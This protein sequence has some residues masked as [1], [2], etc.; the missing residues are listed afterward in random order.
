MALLAGLFASI[1]GARGLGDVAVTTLFLNRV[2]AASL[3]WLFIALGMVSL[4]VALAYGAGIGRL[5]RRAFFVGLLVGF[6]AVLGV[7]RLATLA[8][9]VPVY[10][11]LWVVVNVINAILLT[12]VWTIAGTTLD[13]RQAKRLFPLCTSAAIAGSFAGTLASGPLAGL[14][15]TENLVLL[16][17]VVL[18]L[19]SAIAS[20]IAV[21]QG[22]AARATTVRTSLLVQLRRGFDDV[23]AS[24][25]MRLIAVAYVLFAVLMFSVSFPY[26]GA[27]ATGFAGNEAGLATTVGLI[28]TAVTAISFVVSLAIANRVYVRFGV[29]AAALILPVVYVLGFGVWLVQF[30]LATAVAFVVVQQVVQRSL[31]NAAWSALYNVVPSD[32]RPQVL[33]FIDGVPGQL[34]T[35]LS[36]VLLLLA[37]ALFTASQAPIF[38]MGLVAAIALTWTVVL[39]RRRYGQ[40][41]VSTL[42]AGLAEQ[43]L[44]GGPGLAAMSRA[45]GVLAELLAALGDRNAG[46]RRLAADLLGGLGDQSAVEP[47]IARFEDDDAQV[48]AASVRAVARLDPGAIA[49]AT[50]GLVSSASPAV[51]AEVG[52]ALAAAGDE[53]RAAELITGLLDSPGEPDQVAGLQAAGRVADSSFAPRL[54]TALTDPRRAVRVTA[55]ESLGLLREHGSELGAAALIAALDDEVEAV[56]RAAAR[57]LVRGGSATAV[58]ND[59]IRDGSEQAQEAAVVALSAGGGV[60]GEPVRDWALGRVERAVHL[61]S[62]AAA[63]GPATGSQPAQAF[64]RDI[65]LRRGQ[66]CER[67]LLAAIGALGAPEATGLVRRSLRSTDPDTRAQAIEVIDALGDRRLGR[68]VVRLL[69]SEAAANGSDPEVALRALVDDSDP[70]IRSLALRASIERLERQYAELARRVADDPDP[71]VRTRLDRMQTNGGPLMPD[72]DATLSELD[73]MLFL[74]RVPLFGQLDPEDLQRLAATATERVYQPAEALVREGE[75]GDELI[76]LVEGR[77]R[78][79]RADADGER[80]LRTYEAGDH[81]GELAVLRDRPR[82]ASV[83]AETPIRGLVIGGEG[84]RA[85]LQERPEAAMAMLATLA[86]RISAQ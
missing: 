81:I 50:E 8:D 55:A 44:E 68:A 14:L 29:A 28:Q 32:R 80:L 11:L 65:L 63:L 60:A 71:A 13:A 43:I 26:Q 59:V 39:I 36:G 69:D 45:P 56:R 2:G 23:R 25:L 58:L 7:L 37:G 85:I 52:L 10:G 49:V 72:T 5:P 86:E 27:L 31:S 48:R 70:W 12:I 62:Q 9:T 83:I 22:R 1:E 42:R 46:T 75:P 24:P 79:V 74:R 38:A 4:I 15:G 76:V 33:A 16:D 78:V 30:S 17:A 40:A 61:R 82:V 51:R 19:A 35:S 77:V 3:P 41:L 67:Q 47:L 6:A 54:E 73:R 57:A 20:R 18:L 66:R 53:A 84:L 21:R 34:G 64:I